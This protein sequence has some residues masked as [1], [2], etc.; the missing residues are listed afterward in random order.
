MNMSV[1]QR[2]HPRHTWQSWRDRYHKQLKNRPP[3]AFNIP[4]NAPP[5]PPSDQSNER[6]PRAPAPSKPTKQQTPQTE[7]ASNATKPS[8]KG[9]SK[10]KGDYSVEELEGMFSTDDWLEL[11]AFVEIIESL[12]GTDGYESAWGG[13]AEEQGEQTVDQWQ[14]YYDKVVYPQWL[15]DPVSKRD[16]IR[17]KMERK[18]GAERA[19]EDQPTA[20]ESPELGKPNAIPSA[21]A[22]QQEVG[23]QKPSRSEDKRFEELLK[24]DQQ[25]RLSPAYT[26]YALEKKQDMLNT[27]P[28][29]D[30]G[31]Y[32]EPNFS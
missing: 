30:H 2:Q 15:R 1:D 22:A 28:T 12:K 16:K 32:I 29:L 23:T 21:T 6:I 27:Q 4:D 11:Y 10:A 25:E 19:S 5:S 24:E 31:K 9:K 3:S 13:W 8:R 14:Q 7:Q 18:H 20:Q 26:L 17:R